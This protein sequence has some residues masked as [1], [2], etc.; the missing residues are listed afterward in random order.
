MAHINLIELAY[1]K[2]NR[3]RRQESS[4]LS[5]SL[6]L[7]KIAKTKIDTLKESKKLLRGARDVLSERGAQVRGEGSERVWRYGVNKS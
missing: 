5:L 7:V 2:S 1:E 4:S 3:M 6:E